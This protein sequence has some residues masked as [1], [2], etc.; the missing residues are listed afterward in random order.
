MASAPVAFAATNA[1][2]ASDAPQ[3]QKQDAPATTVKAG[4]AKDAGAI[5][6]KTVKAEPEAQASHNKLGASSLSV[7][8][9][10]D[11][12]D[13]SK[14]AVE[15]NTVSKAEKK[16]AATSAA[17]KPAEAKAPVSAPAAAPAAAAKVETTKAN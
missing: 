8:K 2:V 1:A 4:T 10:T 12:K 6:A 11:K 13:A 3:A 15:K 14:P 17:V 7:G 5:T 16:D 9:K